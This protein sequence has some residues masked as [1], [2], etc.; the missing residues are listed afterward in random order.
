MT[1]KQALKILENYQ[2]WRRGADMPQPYPA[3]VGEAL[4]VAIECLKKKTSK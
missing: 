3:V 1:E 4:D 2:R